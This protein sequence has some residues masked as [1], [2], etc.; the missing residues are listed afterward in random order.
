MNSPSCRSHD[1]A[2]ICCRGAT[3]A[4]RIVIHAKIV[5]HLV[6]NGSSHTNGIIRVV[7]CEVKEASQHLPVPVLCTSG[8]MGWGELLFCTCRKYLLKV[9]LPISRWVE[10]IFSPWALGGICPIYSLLARSFI[11]GIGNYLPCLLL[12]TGNQSTWPSREP[13]LL[14]YL[15]RA[16]P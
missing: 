10:E 9:F 13:S 2:P 6:G 16:H 7:L 14:W 5:S 3:A 8:S 15:W 12:L 1:A 11:L 4:S